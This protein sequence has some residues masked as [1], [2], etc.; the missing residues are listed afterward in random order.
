MGETFIQ[1]VSRRFNPK[2][3]VGISLSGGLDSR[4]IFAAVDY[5]YPNYSGY[6]Y[7]F[8]IP[9]CDDIKIA[10]QVISLASEWKHQTFYFNNE[11][12][13]T[14]RIEKVWNTDGMQDLM[15]MHG[16]EFLTDISNA[17]HINLNGY[18]GDAIL[19]GSLLPNL[20]IDT[21]ATEDNTKSFYKNFVKLTDLNS[22]FYDIQHVEP[23]IYMNRVRRFT[24]YGSI[25]SLPWVEQRKPF[26]D[27]QIM[28]LVF[29]LPEAYRRNNK[30]YSAMLKKKFPK[31]FLDIPW[32]Q[33]GKIVGELKKP[34]I[35]ARALNKAKREIRSL[36]GIQS[37]QNYTDY[38]A[39][40]RDKDVSK[41]LLDLLDPENAEYTR[42]T[43]DDLSKRWLEPHLKSKR[44]NHAHQILRAATIE[45]YLRQVFR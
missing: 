41:Q 30:L 9:D 28:E 39:W 2:E 31:Y 27:N 12:W 23:N 38:P 22:E 24:T 3:K 20:P 13:F 8:G 21:R 36:L 15:H 4:A 32:Q 42:L 7:T 45:I 18:A 16:S 40:I 14:P 5:L 29:S 44:I 37:T 25:N 1:A 6:A 17:M 35:P 34:S 19:G 43:H 11:N 33:T 10:N 26:L